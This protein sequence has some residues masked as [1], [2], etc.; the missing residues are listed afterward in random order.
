MENSK[1]HK[2][3]I[4]E[5]DETSF[6]YY[7]EVISEFNVEI[8]WANNG[9]Q[10]VELFTENQDVSLIIMDIEMPILDGL[11]AT[12]EIRK[13]SSNVPIVVLT[14]YALRTYKEKAEELKADK[15]L[16]KPIRASELVAVVNEFLF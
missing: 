8:I 1:K 3:I 9:K 10:A 14:S 16:N 11:D 2:I 5:N 7:K 6:F 15:F 12:K 13:L 4:A